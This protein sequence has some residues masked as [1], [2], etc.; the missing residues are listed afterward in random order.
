M[1]LP[2]GPRFRF[3]ERF[4][5]VVAKTDFGPVEIH[6]AHG[7]TG[8]GHGWDKIEM[9][10]AIYERLARKVRRH[11]ILCG[12][13]NTPRR[14]TPDGEIITFGQRVRENLPPRLRKIIRGKSGARWDAG[15][16]NI[17]T[18]LKDFD[19]ADVFREIHGYD[20]QEMSWTTWRKSKQFGGR[21]DHIFASAALN[22]TNAEYLHEAREAGLSDHSPL[23]VEC[24]PTASS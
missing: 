6:A 17:L 23:V 18:G 4:L 24:R 13:F 8:T 9:L 5:S 16:R 11:R 10:E 3:P 22:A 19:L 14:E 7:L 15:E 21:F 12:D 20:V 2:D 1:F